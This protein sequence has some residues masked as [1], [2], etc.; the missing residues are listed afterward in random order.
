MQDLTEF[1]FIKLDFEKT[2]T[3]IYLLHNL[4]IKKSIIKSHKMICK[5]YDYI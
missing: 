5:K 4:I 1:A 2:T 3:Y